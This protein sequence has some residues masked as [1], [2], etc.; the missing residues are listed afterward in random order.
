MEFHFPRLLNRHIQFSRSIIRLPMD[1]SLNSSAFG[2][3]RGHILAYA[4]VSKTIYEVVTI[5]FRPP[6]PVFSPH[7]SVVNGLPIPSSSVWDICSVPSLLSSFDWEVFIDIVFFCEVLVY[8]P[9]MGHFIRYQFEVDQFGWEVGWI[10]VKIIISE[11]RRESELIVS[12]HII[13]LFFKFNTVFMGALLG[14]QM[15]ILIFN[16]LDTLGMQDR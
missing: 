4:M 16:L 5:I 6:S 15:C 2:R 12:A 8:A 1:Q 14:G 13:C 10:R 11:N 3:F 9:F 7:S